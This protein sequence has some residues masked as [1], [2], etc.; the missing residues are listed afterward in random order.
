MWVWMVPICSQR[1]GLRSS[2]S[3]SRGL[4]LRPHVQP[5]RIPLQSHCKG[6][7]AACEGSSQLGL[8]RVA[9]IA[10]NV[11]WGPSG[12]HRYTVCLSF[13]SPVGCGQ[14]ELLD[15][16]WD[17]LLLALSAMQM[18]Q[19]GGWCCRS[20]LLLFCEYNCRCRCE[21]VHVYITEGFPI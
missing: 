19:K 10:W 17:S 6:F 14:D 12:C 13:L 3:S 18:L 9:A 2:R 11:R 4:S 1:V 21:Q 8:A 5:Q 7:K 15:N 16:F 20:P